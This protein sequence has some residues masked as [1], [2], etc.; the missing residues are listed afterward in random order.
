MG[1][2]TVTDDGEVKTEWIAG[3]LM[4]LGLLETHAGG[5]MEAGTATQVN[6]DED[7]EHSAADPVDKD[8]DADA[9]MHPAAQ[10]AAASSGRGR[11]GGGK[12]KGGRV[13]ASTTKNFKM[14]PG[15]RH[16]GFAGGH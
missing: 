5:P 13:S 10:Q 16:R 2:V 6:A 12:G 14:G 8:D 11:G 4:K 15:G 3:E 7:V 9:D 1:K